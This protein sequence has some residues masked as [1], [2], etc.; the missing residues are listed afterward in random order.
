MGDNTNIEWCDHTFNPWEGCQN[1]GPGCDN[2]YA[3]N[4]NA[5][6]NKGVAVNWGPGAPRRRTSVANWKRPLAWNA[7]AD[8]FAE[9]NGNRKQRVFC[10][11]LADVFDNAVDPSWRA[12][13]FDLIDKTP[14]LDWLLLTKRIGNVGG[15]LAQM[16]RDHLPPHVWL[17]ATIVNQTEA[18]RDIPKL[19][20]APATIRFLSMEP[21]LGPV[22]LTQIP[23]FGLFGNARILRNLLEC[24]LSD[25]EAAVAGE[26]EVV[27]TLSALETY[28][29]LDGFSFGKTKI[30][31]VIVGGESGP[32]ARPMHPD[33]A[34]S[35]CDQCAEADV[36]FLFKQWGEWRE[37]DGPKTKV[38][39]RKI[40]GGTHWLTRDGM[41]HPSNTAFSIYHEYRV[42]KL[43]KKA[44]GR[45]LDGRTHDGFPA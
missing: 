17:G 20:A 25:L 32:K 22:D 5:R 3:E 13:L 33:W 43:G 34:R 38:G 21:L 24:K 6:W 9:A 2:C 19:L 42:A 44:A 16:G 4:R 29:D 26:S 28:P 7:A 11:S 10:S 36:P 39:N 45:L 15:M 37:T 31:W 35:L 18:D 8:A 1:V 12:D 41:L 27:P 14:N 40:G 30:D 23:I